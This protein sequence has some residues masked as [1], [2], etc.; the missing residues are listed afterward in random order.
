MV[1]IVDDD[2]SVR[3]SLTRLMRSAGHEAR[4]FAD[5]EAYLQAV[6]AAGTGVDWLI[7]DLHMPGMSGL[8]L[9][10]VINSQACPVPV[11]VLTGSEDA[12]LHEIPMAAGAMK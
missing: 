11:I 3:T 2:P 5:A 12:A 7:P 4:A 10:E 6:G 8:D 1:F 9:Q